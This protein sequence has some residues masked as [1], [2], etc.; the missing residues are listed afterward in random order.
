MT[1]DASQ[2]IEPS[3][4]DKGITGML[5]IH[6]AYLPRG[7]SGL[8]GLLLIFHG[9]TQLRAQSFG[10][11][12]HNTTNPASG[13]MG[14][15]SLARPQDLQSAIGANPATLTQFHGTQFS[16]GGA[17]AEPTYNLSYDGSNAALNAIG[18]SAFSGKSGAP[19]AA[20]GNFGVT[21]DLSAAGIPAT[22]GIGMVASSG[23]SAH[24]RDHPGS[25]GTTVSLMVL[26]IVSGVGVDITDRLAAGASLSL[27]TGFLDG[28]W[29]GATGNST[30]YGLRGRLGMDYDLTDRTT[31]GLYYQTRQHF[32]FEENV[33]FPIPGPAGDIY[34]DTDLELP[35]NY[36]LGI[37][38]NSLMDGRL[39]IAVDVLYKEWSDADFMRAVYRDQ[40]V[41][42][43]GTQYTIGRAKLRLGYAYAQNPLLD[44]PGGSAG[45]VTPPGGRPLVSYVQSTLAVTNEHRISGGIGIC[46]VLPGV[47][48]D[49]FAG[50]MFESDGRMLG[51]A[52]ETSL[53]SYF[54]GMGLT[55]HFGRGA[56]EYGG[57]NR[58]GSP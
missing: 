55:W 26:D 27:G 31:V 32:T 25:N 9:S 46:N 28:P 58:D 6:K 54:L 35:S 10:I 7:L 17:W 2:T 16:F 8:L 14:G 52:V 33:R 53:E 4:S 42:Q 5:P 44:T 1:M 38:N 21:Q 40:W 29:V 57:W 48:V 23:A 37:A 20:L 45:G 36:G 34:L 30:A 51:G 11:E 39:L 56:Y 47:D 19:G 3:V 43:L 18:L 12:M 49:I 22:L 24:W 15:A 41:F 13:A 50:G